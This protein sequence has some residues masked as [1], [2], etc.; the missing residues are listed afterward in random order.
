MISI[1]I[2][3][4]MRLCCLF[5]SL[6]LTACTLPQR[7]MSINPAGT[8]H[9]QR[10]MLPFSFTPTRYINAIEAQLPDGRSMTLIGITVINPTERTVR[11]GIVTIE[12]LLLFDASTHNGDITLYRSLSPFDGSEFRNALLDDVQFILLPPAGE[13]QQFGISTSGS[14]ICRYVSDGD[15]TI[16]IIVHQDDSWELQK[17]KN[18]SVPICVAKG[19][20][21]S[22]DLPGIVV[23]Q[24]LQPRR[25]R[26]QLRPISVEPAGPCDAQ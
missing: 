12:G 22:G 23:L 24:G 5:L 3:V 20:A 19:S 17:F 6:L 4:H 15:M 8:E 25:Y 11:V 26:L 7:P 21:K 1:A 18:G 16:D 14:S 10:C 9:Q 13:I 2:K